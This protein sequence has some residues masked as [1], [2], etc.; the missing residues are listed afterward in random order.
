MSPSLDCHTPPDSYGH[1]PDDILDEF[2]MDMLPEADSAPWEE[3][4][5]VCERCQVRVAEADEYIQE[6]KAA[7]AELSR[8]GLLKPMVAAVTHAALF[9]AYISASIAAR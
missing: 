6:M 3:H 7:A 4:L 5:L 1:I 2:A 8:K 9:L